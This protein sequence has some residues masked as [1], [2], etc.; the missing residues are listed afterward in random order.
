MQ[1]PSQEKLTETLPKESPEVRGLLIALGIASIVVLAG[2]PLTAWL[3]DPEVFGQLGSLALWGLG[4]LSGWIARQLGVAPHSLAA[5]VLAIAVIGTAFLS[6]L[7]WIRWN[8]VGAENWQTAISMFP[9]YLW[10]FRT[11][12]LITGLIAAFGAFSV[13]AQVRRVGQH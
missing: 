13:F 2:G 1:E 11:S 6:E 8:I 9:Q 4:F 7:C 12:V 10:D 3:S 5:W